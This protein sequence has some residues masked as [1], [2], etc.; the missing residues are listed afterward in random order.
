MIN[1]KIL[2]LFLTETAKVHEQESVK[3]VNGSS[4]FV[5]AVHVFSLVCPQFG[6]KLPFCKSEFTISVNEFLHSL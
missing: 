1:R 5:T 4:G 6:W 2:F 3:L